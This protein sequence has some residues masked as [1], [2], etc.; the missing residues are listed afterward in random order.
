MA[1]FYCTCEQKNRVW[2]E[3]WWKANE[4]GHGWVYFDD[5]KGSVSYGERVINCSGY[6]QLLHRGTLTPA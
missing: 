6:G 3:F 4:D 1:I 2:A 5:D